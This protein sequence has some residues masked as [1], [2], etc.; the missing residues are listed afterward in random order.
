MDRWS[1]L[2]VENDKILRQEVGTLVQTANGSRFVPNVA[3]MMQ[4][5][6][7]RRDL[8]QAVREAVPSSGT[9][10]LRNRM[11]SAQHLRVN[12]VTLDVPAWSVRMFQAPAG[13]VT[14]ELIGY[15]SPKS[16]TVGPPPTSRI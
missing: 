1:N 13:T 10:H 7:Y 3:N 8:A 5:P 16:L 12:G 9:L 6:E 14:T 4:S 15:E 11:A 2:V